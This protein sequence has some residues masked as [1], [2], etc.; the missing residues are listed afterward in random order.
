MILK[1]KK[2]LVYGL[3][4]SG[5]AVIK[6]LSEKGAKVSFFD[7]DIRYYEY[8]GFEREPLSKKYDFV[9]ILFAKAKLW[10]LQARMEKPPQACWFIEF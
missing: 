9:V 5:R 7:D 3:G 8:V 4:D 6:I 1:N 2:V 10:Q